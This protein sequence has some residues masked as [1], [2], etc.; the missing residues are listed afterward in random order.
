MQGRSPARSV[1]GTRPRLDRRRDREVLACDRCRAQGVL[2]TAQVVAADRL[3]AQR[4]GRDDASRA[5]DDGATWT[6]PGA[7]TK[8]KRPHVVPLAPLARKMVGS[9]SEGFVF[10]TTGRSPVSGW[11]KIKQRL[12]EAMKIPPWRLHDL[13]R[14]AATGMAEIG[15]AP[16]IV[17]AGA[18][19]HQRSQGRRCRHV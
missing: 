12:D 18:E 5:S 7:R 4:S 15:I 3:P 19:S 2:R 16:H 10:T 14:T 17:E 6:I 11:S 1:E 13:R 8:N 9:G